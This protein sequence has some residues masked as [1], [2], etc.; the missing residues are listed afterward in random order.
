M[1]FDLQVFGGSENPEILKG[2]REPNVDPMKYP[3]LTRALEDVQPAD[4]LEITLP[5]G[6]KN[7]QQI[8]REP[9]VY[10]IDGSDFGEK[11]EKALDRL[12]GPIHEGRRN[13]NDL[14]ASWSC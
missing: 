7:Y 12:L 9:F 5:V 11:A 3:V 6:Q 10:K 1:T 8:F 14:Y 13:L 2:L 4:S